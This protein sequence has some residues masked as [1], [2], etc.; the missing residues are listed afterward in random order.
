MNIT[1]IQPKS[2]ISTKSNK[3]FFFK[4]RVHPSLTLKQI[5]YL[6]PQ[7]H[8]IQLIDERY[9]T[10]DFNTKADLIGISCMTTDAPRAYEIATEFHRR[11]KTVVLGGCHPSTLPDEAKQYADAVLIGEA[12]LNWRKLLEDKEN[13]NLKPFYRNEKPIDLY[14]INRVKRRIND[15]LSFTAAVQS[16]RGCPYRCEFCAISNNLYG[17]KHR[18]R[19]IEDVLEEI[20]STKAKYLYFFDPSMTIDLKHTKDLFREMKHLNKKFKC[21]GNI[22]ILEKDDELLKLA[23]EAGCKVWFVGLESVSQSTLDKIGKGNQ[24]NKYIE[25]I[26]KIHD[27]GMSVFGSFIFGFDTDTVSTFKNTADFVQVSGLDT[28]EFY[29]LTPYPGTPLFDRLDKEG[30]ILTKDWS[31]YNENQVVFKPKNM[32]PEQLFNGTSEVRDTVNSFSTRCRQIF[33]DKYIR[34]DI[35]SK[36]FLSM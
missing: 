13:N 3:N 20:K 33:K 18:T 35:G 25:S 6:T 11:E 29:I 12:E 7:T 4:L 31:K 27:Y 21:F 1:L 8:N 17:N 36:I 16:S 24:A 28:V 30:R 10:I 32:T 2:K 15:R 34:F 14:D 26:K 19:R 9:Q 5:A 22:T 23:S